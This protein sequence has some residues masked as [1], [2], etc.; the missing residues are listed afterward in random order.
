MNI[1]RFFFWL[2]L[3]IS[4]ILYL[5]FPFSTGAELWLGLSW[6]Q[7][8]PRPPFESQVLLGG[9]DSGADEFHGF[10]TST[11]IG[12]IHQDKGV[13][14]W[15]GRMDESSLSSSAMVNYNPGT[16]ETR[17]V[18]I[19]YFSPWEYVLYDH[20]FNPKILGPWILGYNPQTKDLNLL[21]STTGQSQGRKYSWAAPILGNTWNE[22]VMSFGLGDGRIQLFFADQEGFTTLTPE[23]DW[24]I[25]GQIADR[26][27]VGM[28]IHD[29]WLYVLYG[30]GVQ[31]LQ[32]WNLSDLNQS[33]F[34]TLPGTGDQHP[35]QMHFVTDGNGSVM[36][37]MYRQQEQIHL[38]I[39]PS[40]NVSLWELSRLPE[41]R[42]LGTLHNGEIT[43]LHTR[44][45]PGRVTFYHYLS[46][47]R[48]LFSSQDFAGYSKILDDGILWIADGFAGRN[49][50]EWID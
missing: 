19:I 22:Q 8:L 18:P 5:T 28:G 27:P 34:K 24:F 49:T 40:G 15:H 44:N 50:I 38:I 16:I 42:S 47:G 3:F 25:L 45:Q 29:Q 41:P 14:V 6:M 21:H 48:A 33:W 13:L 2:S 20:R 31:T 39:Q 30:V 4:V 9:T 36:I 1:R 35:V 46:S 11:G 23:N 17:G 7:E 10:L 37:L 12:M 43:A 32:A 26:L